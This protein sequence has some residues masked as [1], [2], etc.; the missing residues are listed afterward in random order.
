MSEIIYIASGWMIFF[1]LLVAYILLIS[2]VLP[3]CFLRI[4]YSYIPSLG[5]GLKKY[6]FPNGR[7]IL[8]E[9]HPSMRKYVNKYLLFVSDGYKYLKCCF[10]ECVGEIKYSV[11]MIDNKDKVID[12]ISV[13][14]Q[15]RYTGGS[16]TVL[17]HPDTSYVALVLD[18]VNGIEN[19]RL[20]SYAKL[21]GVIM[22]FLSVVAITLTAMFAFKTMAEQI[23]YDSFNIVL[24]NNSSPL[25]FIPFSLMVGAFAVAMFL[26]SAARKGIRVISGEGK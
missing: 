19:E 11:A 1:L 2:D 3:R 22:Y 20:F 5:R 26:I 8:Y 10:D 16:E 4:R 23:V 15:T 21:S 12:V 6:K 7:G 13:E 25:Y 18:S 9:P 17:L 14:E 24:T